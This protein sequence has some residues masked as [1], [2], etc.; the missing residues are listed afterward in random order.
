MGSARG[1]SSCDEIITALRQEIDK[2]DEDFQKKAS[3]LLAR[4]QN[5]RNLPIRAAAKTARQRL[6]SME[7]T[8]TQKG[9]TET[10]DK[11]RQ[12]L[13]HVA[14]ICTTVT[15]PAPL[16]RAPLAS[17]NGHQYLAVI[18]N[19]SWR[20][21]LDACRSMGGHLAYTETREELRFLLK[22]TSNRG[23]LWLGTTDRP[24]EGVWMWLNGLPVDEQ[25]WVTNQ[26][27]NGGGLGEHFGAI[28]K[29]KLNDAGKDEHQKYFGFVCEWE[30]GSRYEKV[31]T[32][33]A[34]IAKKTEPERESN[35]GEALQKVADS[36]KSDS[37]SEQEKIKSVMTTF[38][39]TVQNAESTYQNK[40][41][42][43][44]KLQE[45]RKLQII[46]SQQAALDQLNQLSKKEPADRSKQDA[47]EKAEKEIGNITREAQDSFGVDTLW[48]VRFQESRYL[49][50]LSP[51]TW[52]EAKKKCENMGGHLACIETENEREFLKDMIIFPCQ[53][54]VGATDKHKEGDWRWMNRIP[55]N[56][57]FWRGREPNG[58][59][60]ENYARFWGGKIIDA[61]N[62]TKGG[63]VGF[64]CE[65]D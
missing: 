12:A 47:I 44:K 35:I 51:V 60:K 5:Q 62:S 42:A 13:R 34:S 50:I 10:A 8:A 55:V 31:A 28:W 22:I 25:L 30:S 7:K 1:D 40:Y 21:A 37:D 64:I 56:K 29:G 46:L 39:H 6:Q 43:V 65:W 9:D 48:R 19:V 16:N 33:F 59:G 14:D 17:F 38:L 49:I 58:G 27:D 26:P 57:D 63:L 61:P 52:T 2:I 4:I 18:A 23:A 11:A 54:W 20:E 32:A 36:I 15:I 24:R 53:L 45:K 3:P 41:D